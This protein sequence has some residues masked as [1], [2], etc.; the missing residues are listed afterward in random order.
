[1]DNNI[2]LLN[3]LDAKNYQIGESM[4]FVRVASTLVVTLGLTTTA[5]DVLAKK[6]HCQK[7][8]EDEIASLFDRWNDSLK[9]GDP[10]KVVANYAAKS[11]LLPTVSNVPRLTAEEKVNYFEHFLQKKPVGKIDQR[12]IDIDCTTA[13]DAG[14]YTF[15]FGDGTEVHGRYTFTYKW[16]GR[17]WLI[18]SHHSSKMPE[19]APA[20]H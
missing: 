14:L 20:A 6:S 15:T 7:V 11:I 18:S 16:N 9:T 5:V 19:Q 2:C 17:E 8:S 1:M 4:R 13:L 3:T 12:M 10:Y